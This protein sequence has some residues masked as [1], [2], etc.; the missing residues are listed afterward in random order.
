MIVISFS[1]SSS[2]PV[3]HPHTRWHTKLPESATLSLWPLARRHDYRTHNPEFTWCNYPN[4]EEECGPGDRR[5]VRYVIVGCK[6]R[7]VE[8][9]AISQYFTYRG[10]CRPC[11]PLDDWGCSGEIMNITTITDITVLI[12]M[13]GTLLHTIV[14]CIAWSFL[15][16]SLSLFHVCT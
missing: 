10:L 3:R 2:V 16:H 8:R 5:N 11:N 7:S 1:S 12:C 6:M 14:Q 4:K 13:Y 15:S 9:H